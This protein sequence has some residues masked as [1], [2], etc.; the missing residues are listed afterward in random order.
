MDFDQSAQ[1]FKPGLWCGSDAIVAIVWSIPC[2]SLSSQQTAL[3]VRTLSR[4]APKS[5]A[6]T[7]DYDGTGG[8]TEKPLRS[9]IRLSRPGERWWAG[10][11]KAVHTAAEREF[12]RRTPKNRKGRQNEKINH[13]D[14]RSFNSCGFHTAFGESTT[15]TIKYVDAKKGTITL[16]DGKVY[17]LALKELTS[18]YEVGDRVL[19]TFTT[20]DG[21][22]HASKVEWSSD[23]GPTALTHSYLGSDKRMI[24]AAAV[25]QFIT[26]PSH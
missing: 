1:Q 12:E 3:N 24:N 15:L 21:V 9:C 2:R 13:S 6:R 20:S 10:Q 25:Y 11:P 5:P 4:K 26:A 19:V 16:M 17:M 8:S 22:N 7:W 23:R 18:K 14:C